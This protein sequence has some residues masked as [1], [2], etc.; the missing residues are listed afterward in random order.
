MAFNPTTRELIEELGQSDCQLDEHLGGVNKLIHEYVG[1]W[2]RGGRDSG[3]GDDYDDSRSNPEPFSYSFV[4]NMLA[5]LVYSNPGILVKARRVIGHREVQEAMKSGLKGLI[6]DIPFKKELEL[7]VLDFFFFQGVLMHYVEDDTRW[8][9]GAVRPNLKRI[10]YRDFGVD[11]LA[12]SLMDAEFLYHKYWQDLD[13][14]A[15]D[16]AADPQALLALQP[17]DST[18]KD[19]KDPFPKSKP[20]SLSRKRARLYS[21]WTRRTNTIRLV[22]RDAGV[23]IYPERP[24]YGP[25]TGPY[26]VIQAYPVPGQ[27]YPLSPLVAVEDQIRDLQVH[28]RATARSAARRKSTIIVDGTHASLGE[29]IANADDGEVISVAGFSSTQTQQVELG[30]VTPQQYEY[31]NNLRQILREHSGLTETQRG[32][33]S[34]GTATESSIAAESLN[35][36][37][38]YLRSKVEIATAKVLHSL[39]WFLF[40]TP[41]VI[42][43]V[44]RRDPLTGM[45]T[46][47][48]FFGGQFPGEDS[49][50]WNDYAIKIEPYSMQRVNE[51]LLQ[52][53]TMDFA[54]LIMEMA[55]NMPMVPWIKW[56]E[57][58][59]MLGDALNQ[60]DAENLISW[61]MLGMMSQ[62]PMMPPSALLGPEGGK[63]RYSIPGQ[64]FKPRP[65]GE[66]SNAHP[67]VDERRSEMSRP[68][69]EMYGGTQG[70]PG[71]KRF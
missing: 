16:P 6:E 69:G 44:S 41:G 54:N 13:E 56:Q 26:T 5:S 38:E 14:L 66:N 17:Q 40:H 15:E 68:Y 22:S 20:G 28:A 70:P 11:S 24:Y 34:G 1:R 62:G 52:R 35:N 64:G 39:G 10:N 8:A 2:Y 42:I 67:L 49:G 43:P 3:A 7:A 59:A 33:V 27:P 71:S 29:D 51:S 18:T 25:E 12:S 30:G 48:L 55:P 57:L 31:L 21:V 50:T 36:R 47:G 60:D 65:G 46:E 61:E 53:R 32:Q 19:D 63:D 45:E 9:S 4:S 37:V 58:V 23:E